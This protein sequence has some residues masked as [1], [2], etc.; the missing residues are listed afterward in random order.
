[1]Q[2]AGC[3]FSINLI[4]STTIYEYTS[5][6]NEIYFL[7]KTLSFALWHDFF[8]SYDNLHSHGGGAV[9]A[10]V[11]H[12]LIQTVRLHF[13]SVYS[14]WSITAS[15]RIDRNTGFPSSLPRAIRYTL[16]FQARSRH[17]CPKQANPGTYHICRSDGLKK[18]ELSFHS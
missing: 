16:T 9:S 1:M 2:F 4:F 3:T 6:F 17:L 5:I 13:S 10:H 8:S 18:F 12:R 14:G 11:S 7:Q 15:Q